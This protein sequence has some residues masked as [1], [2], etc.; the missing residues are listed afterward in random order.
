MLAGIVLGFLGVLV[1][2]FAVKGFFLKPLTKIDK[3]TSL[4]REKIAKIK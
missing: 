2:G 4:L 1:L 3:E